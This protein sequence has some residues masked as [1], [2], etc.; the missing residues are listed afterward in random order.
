M[1]DNLN[2]IEVPAYRTMGGSSAFPAVN[3]AALYI[4]QAKPETDDDSKD[5]H[6]WDM[7]TVLAWLRYNKFPTH[8]RKLFVSNNLCGSEFLALGNSMNPRYPGVGGPYPLNILLKNVPVGD[9]D[10]YIDQ[11]ERL[12]REVRDIA[13]R[14]YS[15]S[16]S[17]IISTEFFVKESYSRRSIYELDL[18]DGEVATAVERGKQGETS[19]SWN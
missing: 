7:D 9:D 14:G 12:R 4:G 11:V 6:E 2:S 15:T 10:G 18:K 13:R 3:N 19:S 16:V 17:P 8:W 5:D 1:I